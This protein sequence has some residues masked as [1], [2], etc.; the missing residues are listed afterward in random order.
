[1]KPRVVGTACNPST[2]WLKQRIVS[3]MLP[4]V[5][6]PVPG[7]PVPQED[8]VAKQHEKES[9]AVERVAAEADV[10]LGCG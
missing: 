2:H 10:T 4:W 8:P 7:L 3:L 6:E 9:I 1:M 5:N